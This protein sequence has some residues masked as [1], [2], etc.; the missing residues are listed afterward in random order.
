MNHDNKDEENTLPKSTVDR[1]INSCLPKQ[2][3][4]GKE[5][6][7]MFTDCLLE[8]LKIISIESTKICDLEKK[9][10]ITYEHLIKSLKK[11]GFESYNKCCRN[12]QLEYEK[13]VKSK[14]SKINKFKDSGLSLEEL[15]NQQL[16]LFKNEKKEY[17]KNYNDE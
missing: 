12:A 15:H 13:Y 11:L 1:Y 10:T 2:I 6:K 8:F 4:V 5:A 3:T 17:E 7:E 9:K 16:E 14:P